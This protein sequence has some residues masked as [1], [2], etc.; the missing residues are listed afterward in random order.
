MKF[1]TVIEFL[2]WSVEEL[3]SIPNEAFNRIPDDDLKAVMETSRMTAEA[4]GFIKGLT[5]S[6][7]AFGRTMNDFDRYL[8]E[9]KEQQIDHNGE[10]L[11]EWFKLVKSGSY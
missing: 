2:D 6:V 3:A 7:S 5:M 8:I 10:S 4:Y 9:A 11:T 1:N